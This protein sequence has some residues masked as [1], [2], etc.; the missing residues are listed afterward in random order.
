MKTEILRMFVIE[1][2]N[3]TKFLNDTDCPLEGLIIA[4][5]SKQIMKFVDKILDI[6]YYKGSIENE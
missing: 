2:E 1:S 6:S 4:D 3:E 5:R